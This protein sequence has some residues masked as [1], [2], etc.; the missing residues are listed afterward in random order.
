[1]RC[2]LHQF[3][4]IL[5]NSV[6]SR[7]RMDCWRWRHQKRCKK[8]TSVCFL[9]HQHGSRTNASLTSW[10]CQSMLIEQNSFQMLFMCVEKKLNTELNVLGSQSWRLRRVSSWF[11]RPATV[12]S[13]PKRLQT[14]VPQILT[15][16]ALHQPTSLEL[17]D[18]RE[19]GPLL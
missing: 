7:F 1:M 17:L 10:I 16:T 18:R 4:L 8:W 11:K 3:I 6:F 19:E 2:K 9:S 13:W 5:L 14:T 12:H 15:L